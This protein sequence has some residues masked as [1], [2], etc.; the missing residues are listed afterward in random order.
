ML[1]S[2]TAARMTA[3]I[4]LRYLKTVLR[5]PISYFDKRSPGA[6]ASSLAT[7]T[8]VVQVG[9][10]EKI[11]IAFQVVGMMVTA[12][13]IALT[14]QWKVTLVTATIIPYMLLTTGFFGGLNA[15]TEGQL[16]EVLTRAAGVAEE[17]LSSILNI[18][19]MG[20]KDKILKRY[21]VYLKEAKRQSIKMG[22]L[23]AAIYGNSEFNDEFTQA[24]NFE[25]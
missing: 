23:M 2:F 13:V 16:N 15:K 3:R 4:R 1:W 9:L 11:G 24:E 14:K 6:I 22:P 12:F 19:A 17:A 8:N 7:D 18:T 20:A 25:S 10:S 5:R 21:D